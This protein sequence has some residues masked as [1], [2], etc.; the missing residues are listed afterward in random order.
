MRGNVPEGGDLAGTRGKKDREGQ[1]C[2]PGA[3]AIGNR[4]GGG[5]IVKGYWGY[6]NHPRRGKERDGKARSCKRPAGG[7]AAKKNEPISNKK[8]T[9][10]NT[11]RVRLVRLRNDRRLYFHLVDSK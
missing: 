2:V 7:G 6:L 5:S 8:G 3:A 4:E 11:L 10:V 1:K 9:E